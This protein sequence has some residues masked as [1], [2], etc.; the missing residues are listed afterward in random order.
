[1]II[2]PAE[3]TVEVF[4][5]E[6]LVVIVF[7]FKKDEIFFCYVADNYRVEQYLIGATR[8]TFLIL[9]LI[10]SCHNLLLLQFFFALKICGRR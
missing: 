7:V 8:Y 6:R 3:R 1:M 9:S 10:I 4:K 5:N 2:S